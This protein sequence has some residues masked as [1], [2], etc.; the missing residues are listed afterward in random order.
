MD[1]KT[2]LY[3]FTLKEVLLLLL[4]VF[5]FS[6]MSFILGT[7]LGLE[8]SY[9]KAGLEQGNKDVVQ[10][11]SSEEERLARNNELLKD[12]GVSGEA[13]AASIDQEKLQELNTTSL[14]SALEKTVGAPETQT[15]MGAEDNHSATVANKQ[16]SV[17]QKEN[18]SGGN[19]LQ[20]KFT[21]QLG[22]Y[23]T[24]EEAKQFAEGFTVR[25]YSP[26]L[27]K[28]AIENK[29]VWYRVSLGAFED[30]TAAKNYIIKESSLFDAQDYVIV[31]FD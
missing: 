9:T 30:V 6:V 24:V 21:V 18:L 7:R 15:A 2:K 16:A 27:S 31:K 29:G 5:F 14:N 11:L 26:I 25:G 22:S 12:Q 4:L 23:R 3:V 17:E 20:G 10:I 13:A 19:Q 1:D 28:V 8:H